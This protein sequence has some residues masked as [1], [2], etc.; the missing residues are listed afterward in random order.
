MIKWYVYIEFDCVNN[1]VQNGVN[2]V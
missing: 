1:S 2:F